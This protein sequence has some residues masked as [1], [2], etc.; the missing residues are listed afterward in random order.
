METTHLYANSY[1]GEVV[2]R[3]QKHEDGA[4]VGYQDIPIS[5]SYARITAKA[6]LKAARAAEEHQKR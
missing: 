3:I 6:L 1:F 4:A 5:T 2:L